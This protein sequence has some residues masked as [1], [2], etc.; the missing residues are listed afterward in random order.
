MISVGDSDKSAAVSE[1]SDPRPIHS[2]ITHSWFNF[3]LNAGLIKL[4]DT[5]DDEVDVDEVVELSSLVFL[6]FFVFFSGT[7]A[8]VGAGFMLET[9]FCISIVGDE[10]HQSP[11]PTHL[12]ARVMFI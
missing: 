10:C 9:M 1:K 5:I 6:F 11:L 4:A 12:K 3:K 7:D 2:F 8:G